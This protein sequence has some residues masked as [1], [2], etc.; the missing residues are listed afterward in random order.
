MNEIQAESPWYIFISGGDKMY[1]LGKDGKYLIDNKA[2]E[3]MTFKEKIEAIKY[4][5]KHGLT[6]LATIRKVKI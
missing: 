2:S 4:L 6:R 1:L 3:A 5:E